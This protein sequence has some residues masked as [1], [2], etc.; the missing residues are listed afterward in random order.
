MPMQNFTHDELNALFNENANF[1]NTTKARTASFQP[2]N[3][4]LNRILG[5]NKAVLV[6][7]SKQVK[8]IKVVMN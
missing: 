8:T 7:K 6:Q 3:A 5:Y 2:S 4:V 1:F